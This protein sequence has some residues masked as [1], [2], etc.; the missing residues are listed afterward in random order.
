MRVEWTKDCKSE[1]EKE[2]RREQ[3]RTALPTLLL[4]KDLLE[5]RKKASQEEAFRPKEYGPGWELKQVAAI[6][7]TQ[8]Y[9]DLIELLTLDRE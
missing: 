7:R 1:Q 9:D 4:L 6:T 5:Q 8:V 3:V 2:G